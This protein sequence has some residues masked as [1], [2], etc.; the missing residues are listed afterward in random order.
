MRIPE[1]FK[2]GKTVFSFEIFPPKKTS[3]IDTIYNTL[4]ELSDLNPA[5]ISVTYGT[6][7]LI[8]TKD[9][10]TSTVNSFSSIKNTS[11]YTVSF[12]YDNSGC[13]T[14]ITITAKS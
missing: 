4:D 10:G 5:F 7:K 3:S 6:N 11:T 14:A 13:V 2:E 1:L 12:T 9:D 8:E